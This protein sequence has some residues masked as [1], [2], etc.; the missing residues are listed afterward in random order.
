MSSLIACLWSQLF[1]IISILYKS[2]VGFNNNK[3]NVIDSILIPDTCDLN[4]QR[5]RNGLIISAFVLS[6]LSFATSS[7]IIFL[8]WNK[9]NYFFLVTIIT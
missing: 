9:G 3:C 1:L 7:V 8:L 5:H 4:W 6:V 2:C